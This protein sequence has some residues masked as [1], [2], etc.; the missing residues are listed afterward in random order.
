MYMYVLYTCST[1]VGYVLFTDMYVR[2]H[3][4]ITLYVLHLYILHCTKLHIHFMYP[5]L[6]AYIYVLSDIGSQFTK[7]K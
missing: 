1:Y 4:H 7:Y 2:N 3:V 6:L 5:Q